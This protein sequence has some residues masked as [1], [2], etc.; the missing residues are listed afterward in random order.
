MCMCSF[1]CKVMYLCKLRWHWVDC[2]NYGYY[3]VIMEFPCETCRMMN[4]DMEKLYTC[5]AGA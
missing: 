3:N 5:S 2:V 1:T 4:I